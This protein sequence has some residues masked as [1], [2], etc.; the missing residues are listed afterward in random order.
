MREPYYIL[1]DRRVPRVYASARQLMYFIS[2]R[3]LR[4]TRCTHVHRPVAVSSVPATNPATAAD[5]RQC[6]Q[7]AGREAYR[8][9]KKKNDRNRASCATCG[10]CR[11][12]GAVRSRPTA[13]VVPRKTRARHRCRCS[14]GNANRPAKAED[15][16]MAKTIHSRSRPRPRGTGTANSAIKNSDFLSAEG[17]SGTGNF[18]LPLRFLRRQTKT[19]LP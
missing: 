2:R 13:A 11:L 7:T 8:K 15:D 4:V 5:R 6:I 17:R 19:A 9:K 10:H 18:L 3:L 12:H 1:R 14:T 16:R